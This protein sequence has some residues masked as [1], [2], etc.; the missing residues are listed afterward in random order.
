VT[1][2]KCE[3]RGTCLEIEPAAGV[4][5]ALVVPARENRDAGAWCGGKL[6]RLGDGAEGWVYM[7]RGTTISPAT[8]CRL[9]RGVLVN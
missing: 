9:K 7:L 5:D 2:K 4:F 6:G 8:N 1:G 3:G